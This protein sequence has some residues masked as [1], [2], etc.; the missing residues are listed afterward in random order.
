MFRICLINMPF[1]SLSLPSIA[2][3]QMKS[4]LKEQFKDRV[5]VEI[6]YLNHDFGKYLGVEFYDFLSNSMQSLNAGLGDW[7]FRQLAFP[8]QPDNT[9]KYF[10]R[11]FPGETA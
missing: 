2:L 1:A 9:A 10:E 11:Y 8:D 6:L 4:R 3:T 7:V 5:S